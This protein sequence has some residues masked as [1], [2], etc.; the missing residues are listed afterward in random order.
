MMAVEGGSG[1]STT[2]EVMERVYLRGVSTATGYSLIVLGFQLSFD[3]I[4]WSHYP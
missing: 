2:R 4:D 3:Q 1:K